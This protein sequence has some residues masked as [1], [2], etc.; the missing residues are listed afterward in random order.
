MMEDPVRVEVG[1]EAPAE[2]IR[3][4]VHPVDWPAK[5]Q[6]LLHLLEERT[7]GQVLIF[8]RRRD[9]TSYL[10]EY[11]DSSGVSVDDLHGGKPQRLR[12]RSL[13]RFR[14][15][16]TRVLV[17]TNVAARGLDI[18]GIRHVINFDVPDDPRD[19]VHRVGRTARGDD[20]GEAVTL[21]SPNDWHLVRDIETLMGET[22]EREIVPEYEPATTPP[23]PGPGP[24]AK[25]GAG[26]D[27]RPRSALSRGV[28]RRKGR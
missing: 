12:D 21:M 23:T 6:L 10:A 13:E 3:Q 15:G 27:D 25:N 8:T 1:L 14:A 16:E 26:S 11:F 4:V 22:I 18:C 9:T 5:H 20:T 2:G 19:Y 24:A 28:R 7:D 17:A